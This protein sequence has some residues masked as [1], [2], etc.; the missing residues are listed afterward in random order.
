MRSEI[1]FPFDH[2]KPSKRTC[3]RSESCF[4]CREKQ[5]RLNSD[6][7]AREFSAGRRGTTS[8]PVDVVD[9]DAWA[10]PSAGGGRGGGRITRPSS[11]ACKWHASWLIPPSIIIGG[12][13]AKRDIVVG[14]GASVFKLFPGKGE[15]LLMDAP[16]FD[17]IVGSRTRPQA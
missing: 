14:E 8:V 2:I 13:D 17:S 15:A 9:E 7:D 3:Q 16:S 5:R 1:L 4:G 12:Y 6:F 10:T 11:G